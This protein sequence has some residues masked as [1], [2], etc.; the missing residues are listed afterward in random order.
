[1]V[2]MNKMDIKRHHDKIIVQEMIEIAAKN[3]KNLVWLNKKELMD[4]AFQRIDMCVEIE[5]KTFCSACKKP[6][7][8]KNMKMMMK[9]VM[10]YS[11]W[12][13]MFVHPLLVVKHTFSTTLT[14]FAKIP[15]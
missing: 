5:H 9:K 6:C 8:S 2:S 7:Y 3:P 1:M 14:H 13:M 12:R 11:G 10:R 15:Q 4:Y